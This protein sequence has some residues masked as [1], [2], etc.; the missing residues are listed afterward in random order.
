[1]LKVLIADDKPSVTSGLRRLVPWERL[2]ACVVGECA[3]GKEALDLALEQQPD[4]VI[5]DIRM[6]VMDGLEL[7]KQLHERMP[8][9]LLIVLSAFHDFAYAQTAMRY[10][11]SEYILKPIDKPKLDMLTEK[12][13]QASQERTVRDRFSRLMFDDRMKEQLVENLK[14]GDEGT[15]RDLFESAFQDAPAV[16]FQTIREI[17]S[18]LFAI[19][20]EAGRPAASSRKPAGL[21]R[22]EVWERLARA[23][24][25]DDLRRLVQQMLDDVVEWANERKQARASFVVECLKSIIES[26]YADP[27]ITIYSIAAELNLSPNY[28]SVLYRQWTGENISAAITRLRMEQ[29]RRL[30]RE[31]ALSI[32]DVAA[33]SGYSDPHYF[34]KAF[35]KYEGITPSQ[36]RNTSLHRGSEGHDSY[37]AHLSP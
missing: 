20:L 7:C 37:R 19:L 12:I 24:T 13:A 9:T 15:F 31:P 5:T 1:M 30:L 34:A 3:N 4:V 23:R 18:R 26:K 36:Y 11:V 29:A 21:S 6:P 10:G 22:E 14:S 35:K 17:A 32:Q 25:K 28:I 8:N 2:N 16:Q 27:D 33:Q